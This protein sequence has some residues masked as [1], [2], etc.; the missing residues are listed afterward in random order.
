MVTVRVNIKVLYA[1]HVKTG[2]IRIGRIDYYAK[3]LQEWH[4]VERVRAI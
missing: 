2:H 1:L 4:A 3:E